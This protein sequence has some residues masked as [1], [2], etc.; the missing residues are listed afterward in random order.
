MSN[1][2]TQKEYLSLED[3]SKT[4]G[5]SYK[6]FIN[7]LNGHK[8]LKQ[9]YC[10]KEKCQGRK[11]LVI[12]KEGLV[13][14]AN[15]KDGFRGNRYEKNPCNNTFSRGKRKIA[16]K[17][18]LAQKE[19]DCLMSFIEAQGRILKEVVGRIEKLEEKPKYLPL[20]QSIDEPAP[21]D[22]RALLNWRIRAFAV[23]SKIPHQFIWSRL[24]EQ[25]YY[26]Y[27]INLRR[28]AERD[29]ITCLDV[30]ENEGLM[31][32]AFKVACKIFLIK[33]DKKEPIYK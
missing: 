32:E 2:E 22:F 21:M 28:R 17:A 3:A 10:Y 1:L 26:R 15:M 13:V 20:P 18:I 9:D 19:Q 33:T 7:W 6:G 14:I 30:I 31:E 23:E 11:K 27:H 12:L 4:L 16:E 8:S 5:I 24:Y 29:S 25:M